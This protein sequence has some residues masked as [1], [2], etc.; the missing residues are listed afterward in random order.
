MQNSKEQP[1]QRRDEPRRR[2]RLRSGKVANMNG[3]FLI[4]CQIFDRSQKGA[5]LRLSESCQLPD[6]IKLFDDE[7]NTLSVAVIIWAD[8]RDIGVEFLTGPDSVA[9]DGKE[10][11]ALGGR[12]YALK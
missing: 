9:T 1:V 10:H 8:D 3:S 6:H 11:A 2:T 7:H 5:R 4:D 12:Y